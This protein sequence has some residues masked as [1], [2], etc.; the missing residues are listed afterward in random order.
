MSRKLDGDSGHGTAA[1]LHNMSCPP[2]T[3]IRYSCGNQRGHGFGLVFAWPALPANPSA[4][5]LLRLLDGVSAGSGDRDAEEELRDR[6]NRHA[7]TMPLPAAALVTDKAFAGDKQCLDLLSVLSVQAKSSE[8]VYLRGKE[9]NLAAI[10][11]ERR[12]VLVLP[13]PAIDL[14]SHQYGS[15]DPDNGNQA[16][17]SVNG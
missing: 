9:P 17:S 5:D 4:A 16:P 11:R 1:L 13:S 7:S 6:V 8:R 10:R 14:P 2:R 3:V 15:W 12:L